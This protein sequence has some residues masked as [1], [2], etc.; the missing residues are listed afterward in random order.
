MIRRLLILL[1][2]MAS[3]AMADPF[4]HEGYALGCSPE[5]CTVYAA[6]F[7]MNVANDGST[8]AR[9][10]AKLANLALLTPVTL[11]GDL[12]ELGDATAPLTLTGLSVRT[13]DPYAETL[14]GMQGNWRQTDDTL[15]VT[16]LIRGLEWTWILPDATAAFLISPG[17][18]CADG[19]SPGGIVLSLR[20]MGGDPSEN[21]CYRVER[22]TQ[23]ELDLRNVK[24][25]VRKVF[26][27]IGN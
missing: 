12:G 11:K 3:P 10:I 16:L 1:G 9:I 4:V 20:E 13:G 6:G 23:A 2:V 25:D 15:S 26:Q 8:P 18:T 19:T 5:G 14:R 21:A 24:D 17:E 22:V 27:R 7:E